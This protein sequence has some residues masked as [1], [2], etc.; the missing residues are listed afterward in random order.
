MPDYRLLS[1]NF[2]QLTYFFSCNVALRQ[3]KA[4]QE[5]LTFKKVRTYVKSF[6]YKQNIPCQ[7]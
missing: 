7:R 2:S 6:Q 4:K 1:Q 3:R 5:S